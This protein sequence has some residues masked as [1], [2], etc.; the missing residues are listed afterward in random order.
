MN[1]ERRDIIFQDDS[2]VIINKPAGLLVHPSYIDKNETESAMK[3]LRD[4]IG[5]KRGWLR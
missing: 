2:L 5:R 4:M 3:Q 1:L